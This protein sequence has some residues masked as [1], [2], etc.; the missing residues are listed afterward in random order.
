MKK[1]LSLYLAGALLLLA[2]V[3]TLDLEHAPL[4][5]KVTNSIPYML[6]KDD[7]KALT[8]YLMPY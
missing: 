1:G 5:K 8:Q 4:S 2:G 6:A 3:S 7:D